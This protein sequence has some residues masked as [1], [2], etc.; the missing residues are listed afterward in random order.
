[1]SGTGSWR[2]SLCFPTFVKEELTA[3][4]QKTPET[5]VL[6]GSWGRCLRLPIDLDTGPSAAGGW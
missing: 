1:M 5:A 3:A 4:R 2:R 6:V